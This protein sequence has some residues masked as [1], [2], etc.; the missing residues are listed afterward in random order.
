VRLLVISGYPPGRYYLRLAGVVPPQWELQDA[1]VGGRSLANGLVPI[2]SDLRGIVVTVSKVSAGCQG[3]A[4]DT[5]GRPRPDTLV[6]AFAKDWRTATLASDRRFAVGEA[7]SEGHFNIRGLPRGDYLF[8]AVGASLGG[9]WQSA[10]V[11]AR[12]EATSQPVTIGDAPNNI[13]L[14][15][16]PVR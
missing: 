1:V 15:V 14:T 12:L 9:E 4:L 11:L 5:G 7:D 10:A 6:Y 3:V 2:D 8:S 13:T 16:R